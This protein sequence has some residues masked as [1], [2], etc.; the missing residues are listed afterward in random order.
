MHKDAVPLQVSGDRT[1]SR[2][3]CRGSALGLLWSQVP[4]RGK[5]SAVYCWVTAVWALS[6]A[7]GSDGSFQAL[8]QASICC[9]SAITNVVCTG[10]NAVDGATVTWKRFAIL[11]G[12]STPAG[13][14]S[15]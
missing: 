15:R 10:L 4:V 13:P 6:M 12:V 14:G 1:P 3:T 7:F 11:A 5:P 8:C 2:R 9:T